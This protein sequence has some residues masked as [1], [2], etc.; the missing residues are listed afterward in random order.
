ARRR[1]G[2]TGVLPRPGHPRSFSG[3]AAAA[4]G[5]R[6]D[7]PDPAPAAPAALDVLEAARLSARE[8]R[9]VTL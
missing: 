4:G 9:T 7:T 1:G 3:A 8:G 5:A 2:G 6:G